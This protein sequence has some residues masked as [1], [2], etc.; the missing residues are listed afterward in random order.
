VLAY[1]TK[2][3]NATANKDFR[4]EPPM[5]GKDELTHLIYT[6]VN[7]R[8]SV[9]S[10]SS[11]Q[12][13]GSTHDSKSDMLLKAL[14]VCDANVMVADVDFNIQ[15]LNKSVKEMLEN[16]QADIQ[17][18]LPSFNMNTLL[19][20][21]IDQFHKNPAHQRGMVGSLSDTYTT[22]IEVGGRTFHLIANPIHSDSGTRLGTIVEWQDITEKLAKEIEEA[23]VAAENARTRQALDVCQANVMMA[24]ADLNIVYLNHSVKEMLTEAQ[25]EIRQ[26][27]PNFDVNSLMGFNVD[28]FHKDPSHQ[29][30]ML[31]NLK[32]VYETQ[33]VVS[34]RT[35]DLVATPVW[36]G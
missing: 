18:D 20:G 23:R 22:Q 13:A 28:G 15:Y 5:K 24:D 33:I 10:M 17:K 29:R 36:D 12:E 6:L 8:N 14:D 16:A 1:A 30:G 34:G 27:L 4:Y 31:K 25:D 2:S 9:R 19:G 21:N 32:D 7:L 3:A 35:F 11:G 26:A